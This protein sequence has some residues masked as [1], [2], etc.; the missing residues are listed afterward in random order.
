ME[1]EEEAVE[2][3]G[4]VGEE[5]VAWD[6]ALGDVVEGVEDSVRL[7]VDEDVA[8]AALAD[9]GASEAEDVAGSRRQLK[10]LDHVLCTRLYV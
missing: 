9:E 10:L 2:E 7:V 3:A 8:E 6:E 5:E 1:E 4:V